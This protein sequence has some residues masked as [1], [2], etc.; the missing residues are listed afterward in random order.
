MLSH[1]MT[2][3]G[4]YALHELQYIN[5]TM[6]IFFSPLFVSLKLVDASQEELANRTELWQSRM[7]EIQ[8]AIMVASVVEVITIM[9]GTPVIFKGSICHANMV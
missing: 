4:V 6:H 7:R 2:V 8:G 3:C 5:C 9:K 1:Y